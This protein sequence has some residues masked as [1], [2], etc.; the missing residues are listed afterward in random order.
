[1]KIPLLPLHIMTSSTLAVIRKQAGDDAADFAD[2]RIADLVRKNQALGE[3][4]KLR[5]KAR[6]ALLCKL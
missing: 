1:M 6:K 2:K 4:I 5:P 3:I